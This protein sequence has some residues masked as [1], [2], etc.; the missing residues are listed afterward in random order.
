MARKKFP[1]WLSLVPLALAGGGCGLEVQGRDILRKVFPPSPAVY[2]LQLKSPSADVRRKAVDSLGRLRKVKE[3]PPVLKVL[4]LVAKGDREPTVRSAAVKAMGHIKAPEFA[5]VLAG[6]LISDRSASVRTDAATAL[7]AFEAT[8]A[9]EA[10]ITAIGADGDTDVRIAA[11]SGL[12]QYNSSKA[13]KALADALTDR[14]PAVAYE[15]AQG[16]RYITGKNLPQK[17]DQWLAYLAQNKEPFADYGRMPPA[18]RLVD[19]IE[20]SRDRTPWYKR[21]FP[22]Q[23]R[24]SELD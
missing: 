21:F 7:G 24:K 15:S 23:G 5:P 20:Q 10:L 3:L 14:Y 2:V 8:V 17:Q 6:V 4:G 12:R 1:L 19:Q 18:E 11:A 13:A 22:R 9:Q 16:L